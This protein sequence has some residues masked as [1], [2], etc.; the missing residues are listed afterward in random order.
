VVAEA[1][2]RLADRTG[3]DPVAGKYRRLRLQDHLAGLAVDVGGLDD[4][5][6]RAAR[7]RGHGIPGYR[8]QKDGDPDTNAVQ[9]HHDASPR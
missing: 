2:L 5:Q 8:D 3:I 6:H 4:G 1:N 7:R 9:R